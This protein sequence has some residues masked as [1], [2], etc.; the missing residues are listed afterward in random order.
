MVGLVPI[1]DHCSICENTTNEADLSICDTCNEYVCE[2]CM[3]EA[4]DGIFCSE[5]CLLRG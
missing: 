5:D 4:G 3:E 1:S 2:D